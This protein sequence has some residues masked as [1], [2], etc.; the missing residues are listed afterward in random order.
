MERFLF[1][2]DFV[3]VVEESFVVV[4]DAE[5]DVGA[6]VMAEVAVDVV[7]QFIDAGCQLAGISLADAGAPG[8]VPLNILRA[9]VVVLAGVVFLL[10][11]IDVH[12]MAQ[13]TL[14]EVQGESRMSG[15]PQGLADVHG[16]AGDIAGVVGAEDASEFVVKHIACIVGVHGDDA[17]FGGAAAEVVDF[18]PSGDVSVSLVCHSLQQFES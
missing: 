7:L 15:V 5:A 16:V 13:R 17:A 6:F 11:E 1:Q 18:A 9:G 3:D 12:Q 8:G 2:S 14:H 10:V 4:V